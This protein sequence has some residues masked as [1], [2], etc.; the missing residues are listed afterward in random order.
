MTKTSG[1]RRAMLTGTLA[2][3]AG[4]L[5]STTALAAAPAS[6]KPGT[7]KAVFQVSDNDPKKWH[8]TLGN[9]TALQQDLGAANVTVEIVVYGPGINMLKAGS[10]V[11]AKVLETQEANVAVLACQNSMR[12]NH[13]TPEDMLP[14]VGYVSSG[15]G[16]LVKR[17]TEGYACIR[18]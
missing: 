1:S 16:E 17:Q 10:E 8:L 14:K 13:L 3:T 2:A 15:V 18:S 11:A 4:A 5:A 9:V 12:G 6:A 7:Y